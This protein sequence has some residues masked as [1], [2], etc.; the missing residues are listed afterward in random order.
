M[1][2]DGC[3]THGLDAF[4]YGKCYLCGHG[5]SAPS[6]KRPKRGRAATT[7]HAGR[8]TDDQIH[9]DQRRRVLAA[10][11]KHGPLTREGLVQ[12]SGVS[13]QTMCWR[14][15]ELLKSGAIVELSTTER[16]TSG[17]RGHLLQLSTS[18]VP[19]EPQ[20]ALPL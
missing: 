19:A 7:R 16:T 1:P 17:G 14:V 18:P 9:A 15:D 4:K 3:P 8:M 5:A 10:L 13:Y 6:A 2:D 11:E 20:K 12:P